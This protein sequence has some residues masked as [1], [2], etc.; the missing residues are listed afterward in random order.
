[1]QS[2]NFP[3]LMVHVARERSMAKV[4]DAIVDGVARCRDVVLARIW[5]VDKGDVCASCRFRP[6]C[7]DQTRCLHLV[8]SA[9]NSS[10]PAETHGRLD[11]AFRRFPLGVRKIGRVG[12]TG[13]PLLVSGLSGDEPWVAEPAWIRREGVRSFA[14]QPLVFRGEGLGVFAIFDRG[15]LA[16]TDFA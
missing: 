14:A 1:M 16:E 2:A 15:V 6:E 9:G 12:A 10:E 11:G 7:P 13:E 3:Q 5:L 8:A 4:L